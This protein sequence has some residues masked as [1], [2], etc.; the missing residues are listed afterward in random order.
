VGASTCAYR[1]GACL[2]TA[3]PQ[4]GKTP[5]H[6]AAEEGHAAVVEKLLAAGAN[7]E[8][9]DEVRGHCKVVGVFLVVQ[10]RA[11]P[12]ITRW[13]SLEVD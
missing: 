12:L 1:E 13:S 5:L 8:A 4:E 3:A 7:R 9:K 2:S 11:H 6:R 10:S